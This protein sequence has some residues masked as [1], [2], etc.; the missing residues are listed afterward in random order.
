MVD[1][2]VLP[3]SFLWSLATRHYLPAGGVEP[4]DPR[5][6]PLYYGGYD[7]ASFPHTII[8]VGTRDVLLSSGVRLYWALRAAGVEHKLAADGAIRTD[9]DPALVGRVALA[10]GVPLVE[11]RSADGAGL[12]E[13]FLELTAESQRETTPTPEKSAA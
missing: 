9:A 11:L 8:T 7:A 6:S 4:T 3:G 13:M 1:R 2:D 5:Y 10:A 12:E